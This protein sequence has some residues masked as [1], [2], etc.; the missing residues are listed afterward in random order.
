MGCTQACRL[1]Q[2][3]KTESAYHRLRSDLLGTHQAPRPALRRSIVPES[4]ARWAIW[5]RSL[6]SRAALEEKHPC[7]LCEGSAREVP[8][9]QAFRPGG[10]STLDR[11]PE[12]EAKLPEVSRKMT[13]FHIF[14]GVEPGIP[15]RRA[16]P[17]RYSPRTS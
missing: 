14:N 8:E 2:R 6:D 3:L 9:A 7:S 11:L 12:Q 5:V 16:R 4:T 1:R 17:R 13:A 10:G 15:I